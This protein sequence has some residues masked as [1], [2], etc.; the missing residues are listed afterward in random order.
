MTLTSVVVVVVVTRPATM[1]ETTVDHLTQR[2]R[3]GVVASHPFLV[4]PRCP[5]L[6]HHLMGPMAPGMPGIVTLEELIVAAAPPAAPVIMVATL[7]AG[8]GTR[9]V[10]AGHHHH[11]HLAIVIKTGDGMTSTMDPP[12]SQRGRD[13]IPALRT[14][15]RSSHPFRPPPS[16]LLQLALL[17]SNHHPLLRPLC[18]AAAAMNSLAITVC[19]GMTMPQRGPAHLLHQDLHHHPRAATTTRHQV[20]MPRH[21]QSHMLHLP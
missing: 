12:P 10:T 9:V 2:I 14:S 16:L 7:I 18:A 11:H 3:V 5:L 1:I 4:L 6:H 17:I 8:A 13:R 15:T 19:L 21:P 20:R